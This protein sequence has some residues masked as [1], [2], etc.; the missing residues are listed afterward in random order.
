MPD[1]DL[2]ELDRLHA[3]ATPGP[4]Y[5]K[6]HNQVMFMGKHGWEVVVCTTDVGGDAKSI[7]ALHNAYP[8]LRARIAELERKEKAF[9]EIRELF[10]RF[11][12]R[13]AGARDQVLLTDDLLE[14]TRDAIEAAVAAKESK[15]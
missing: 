10:D 9:D 12:T 13:F 4:W 8:S 15:Q 2:A 5:R 14:R 3:E 6:R 1:L 7:I 11:D